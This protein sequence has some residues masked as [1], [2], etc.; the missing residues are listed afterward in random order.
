MHEGSA[1]APEEQ[2]V[3]E[4]VADVPFG[5]EDDEREPLPLPEWLRGPATAV[6][7][8]F[9][10]DYCVGYTLSWLPDLEDDRYA[11]IFI[12]T[13]RPAQGCGGFGIDLQSRGGQL[14]IELAWGVQEHYPGLAG[15]AG[16]FHPECPGHA[17]AVAPELSDG[18]A[19]WSCPAD[20]RRVAPIGRW[21]DPEVV[22][23]PARD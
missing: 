10:G 1:D 12:A 13:E 20:G 22:P 6:L 18:E 14:L 9:A 8:D 2:F 23:Q 15:D 5:P 4:I 16:R 7:A 11:T 3:F 17:H 21:H 19:W